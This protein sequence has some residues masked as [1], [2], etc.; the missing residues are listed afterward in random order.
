MP[1]PT[2]KGKS[3]GV[4]CLFVFN[5]CINLHSMGKWLKAKL[6]CPAIHLSELSV[7]LAAVQSGVRGADLFQKVICGTKES[8]V[9]STVLFC[10]TSKYF[11]RHK[12]NSNDPNLQQ[13]LKYLHCTFQIF[14]IHLCLKL[15][16]NHL[17]CEELSDTL[18]KK[19]DGCAQVSHLKQDSRFGSQEHITK[20]HFREQ[21]SHEI[22]ASSLFYFFNE[23]SENSADSESTSS[24]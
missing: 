23:T 17:S 24:C 7:T 8:K 13:K 22:Q 3:S 11:K 12:G 10:L 6:D 19:G 20:I 16:R 2:A 9:N 18:S 14:H 1:L 21:V 4:F 15:P 5:N